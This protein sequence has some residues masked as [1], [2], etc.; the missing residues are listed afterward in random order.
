MA[1]E[2][3]RTDRLGEQI[4]RDLATAIRVELKDPRVAMVSITAV[5]VSRDLSHARVYVT[6]IGDAAQRRATVEALNHAAGFLR[7][8]LR[9]RLVARVVPQLR[10]VYDESIERGAQLESLIETVVAE[11]RRGHAGEPDDD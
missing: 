7:H 9:Q 11:D 4:R 10:F 3:A 5:R 2:F 8:E 1:K 6:V